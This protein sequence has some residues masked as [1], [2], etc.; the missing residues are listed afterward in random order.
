MA[1]NLLCVWWLIENSMVHCF[2]FDFLLGVTRTAGRRN[3]PIWLVV[4]G[5]ATLAV[6]FFRPPAAFLFSVL[7]LS[8]F[9]KI[10]L[11]ISSPDLIVPMAVV[12]TLCTLKEGFSALLLSWISVSFRSPTGGIGEQLLIPLLLDVL[13]FAALRIVKKHCPLKLERSR[14][15]QQDPDP[16]ADPDHAGSG[17]RH[18]SRETRKVTFPGTNSTKRCQKRPPD[19]QPNLLFQLRSKT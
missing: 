9:A 1:A 6:I 5:A 10:I 4:N 19:F 16:N 14:P 8:V 18:W 3:L 12:L 7:I 2:T 17:R 15:E 11:N 13:L